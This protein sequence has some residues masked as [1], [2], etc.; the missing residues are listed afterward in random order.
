M[1]TRVGLCCSH[2][3]EVISHPQ[4]LREVLGFREISCVFQYYY[5]D[6]LKR[7]NRLPD[8]SYYLEGDSLRNLNDC[9]DD[10]DSA[11]KTSVRKIG[12]H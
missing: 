12:G 6:I 3:A 1:A 8:H 4:G 7:W 10:D 9:I 11:T 5:E 2:H